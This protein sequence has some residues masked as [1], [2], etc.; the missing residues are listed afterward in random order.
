METKQIN[1]KLSKNLLE[2]VQRY[3]ENFGY[4][5][6]QELT[7]E[8][9]RQKIFAENEFDETFTNQEIELIDKLTEQTLKQKDFSTEEE[10][11]KILLE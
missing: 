3:S 11:N 9:L 8:C 6:I 5:N 1:L 10:M 2:A 7:A 4:R